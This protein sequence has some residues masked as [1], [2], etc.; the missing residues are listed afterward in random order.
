[1]G[2]TTQE[3]KFDVE[4]PLVVSNLPSLPND[5]DRN[6]ITSIPHTLLIKGTT[7]IQVD[8]LLSL[9]D[10][11][12]PGVPSLLGGNQAQPIISTSSN[13]SNHRVELAK[14]VWDATI[15]LGSA[16]GLGIL[17]VATVSQFI[18]KSLGLKEIKQTLRGVFFKDTK[19][20]EDVKLREQIYQRVILSD[21]RGDINKL[22]L[23]AQSVEIV[24]TPPSK[25]FLYNDQVRFAKFDQAELDRILSLDWLN[26]LKRREVQYLQHLQDK[27]FKQSRRNEVHAP[28]IVNSNERQ[29]YIP[30]ISAGANLRLGITD[31][32]S[33]FIEK[34]IKET[35]PSFKNPIHVAL[36]PSDE[37]QY[38]VIQQMMGLNS[39]FSEYTKH[40]M[41]LIVV[42]TNVDLG[43][44]SN[45][46]GNRNYLFPRDVREDLKLGL[47]PLSNDF[48]TINLNLSVTGTYARYLGNFYFENLDR[49]SK[50][51]QP[52]FYISRK[53][54]EYPREPL[55]KGDIVR[56]LNPTGDNKN[57]E[58]TKILRLFK[59]GDLPEDDT[60]IFHHGVHLTPKNDSTPVITLDSVNSEN[61]LQQDLSDM[62][63]QLI[64]SHNHNDSFTPHIEINRMFDSLRKRGLLVLVDGV[65]PNPKISRAYHTEGK[66]KYNVLPVSTEDVETRVRE[67]MMLR[68][69][70]S[71]IEEKK[72]DIFYYLSDHKEI[73]VNTINELPLGITLILVSKVE[74][75]SKALDTKST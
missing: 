2:R 42:F 35:P 47:N 46:P 61:S 41:I 26:L 54:A 12:L 34:Q 49:K 30:I 23:P 5:I 11:T 50:G 29:M 22:E 27:N 63:F 39:K 66:V 68:A 71:I 25:I 70:K 31:F 14:A 1:M 36:N 58:K 69:I 75:Q 37:F 60:C 73:K 57:L 28:N 17:G 9:T 45:S 18:K 3:V 64:I 16:I 19:Q 32:V 52:Y 48:L 13:Y 43:N 20:I 55:K 7:N 15:F 40:G 10:F 72:A 8:T 51:M 24:K 62:Y 67:M 74:N 33:K 4:N 59:K 53:I 21:I 56:V 38:S 65:K 6:S 44:F